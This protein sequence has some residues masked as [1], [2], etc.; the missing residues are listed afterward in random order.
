MLSQDEKI[1]IKCSIIEII[2]A[3]R[4]LLRSILHKFYTLEEKLHFFQAKVI[5]EGKLTVVNNLV[6][7]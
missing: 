5:Q 4:S 1:N 2:L 3:L 7:K 6:G